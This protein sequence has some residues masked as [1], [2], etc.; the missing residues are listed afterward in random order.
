MRSVSAWIIAC[1]SHSTAVGVSS[2]SIRTSYKADTIC[3]THPCVSGASA[4]VIRS[5]CFVVSEHLTRLFDLIA[6]DQTTHPEASVMSFASIHSFASGNTKTRTHTDVPNQRGF[7]RFDSYDSTRCLVIT[8]SCTRY[9]RRDPDNSLDRPR[10]SR[11]PRLALQPHG[12]NRRPARAESTA[13][14]V[15][16]TRSSVMESFQ[17][18]TRSGRTRKS[19][20]TAHTAKT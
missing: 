3:S 19:N 2:V 9:G 13:T 18:L 10:M 7:F 17:S 15:Q 16:T 14:T 20:S 1:L 8:N 5:P 11:C 6:S 4:A 12:K